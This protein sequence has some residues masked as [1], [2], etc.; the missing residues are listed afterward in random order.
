[1]G[2]TLAEAAL[3]TVPMMAAMAGIAAACLRANAASVM[4][5]LFEWCEISF[6]QQQFAYQSWDLGRFE[7][8]FA[9]IVTRIGILEAAILLLAALAAVYY[10]KARWSKVR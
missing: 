6:A 4:Q 1:M 7:W 2:R 8:E 10:T 9:G 3:V 5:T